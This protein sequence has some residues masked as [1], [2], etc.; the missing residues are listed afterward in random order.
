LILGD[1]GKQSWKHRIGIRGQAQFYRKSARLVE[2]N[3]VGVNT[4]DA[5][6][7]RLTEQNLVSLVKYECSS[8]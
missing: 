8:F 7:G 6:E 3:F 5:K 4:F 2:G 1:Y